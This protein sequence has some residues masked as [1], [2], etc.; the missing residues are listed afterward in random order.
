M[1]S[2]ASR[3]LR[4]TLAIS[5]IVVFVW[6]LIRPKEY[7]TWV[8]ETFPAIIGFIVLVL[9]YKRFQFTSLGY[10]LLWIHG[11]IL[12]VGGH[13]TYAEMPLFS[14]L[15]DEFGLARNYY[16]RLGHFAQG[17][18]PTIVARELLIRWKVVRGSAWTSFVVVAIALAISATYELFEWTAA[19]I[20]GSA[21]DAFLGTQGDVWD[22]Q[23]DM[24]MALF[25]ALVALFTLSR[26]HDRQLAARK[27]PLSVY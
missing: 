8:L 18:V 16:D 17:F 11:V 27:P 19:I 15:R 12:L 13:Y 3:S 1:S 2:A 6:S 26:F 25:G 7:G 23:K 21:A 5:F 14:W 9:T 10:L 20:G 4:L 22:T 24:L